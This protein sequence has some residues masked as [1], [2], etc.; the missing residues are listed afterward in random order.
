[1]DAQSITLQIGESSLILKKDGTATL[2]G[3][4]INLVGGSSVNTHSPSINEN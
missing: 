1:M 2:N 4:N 3:Q